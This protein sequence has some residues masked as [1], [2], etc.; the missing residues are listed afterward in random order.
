MDIDRTRRALLAA[1]VGGG[2][3]AATLSPAGDL[4]DR[5][6]AP[7]GSAWE[8]ARR[9]VPDT[10]ESPYGP[11]TVTYDDYHVPHVEADTEDAVYFAVGY[12]Q[13]ADR[14]FE[15]DLIRRRMGGTLSAAFGERTLESDRFHA[16]MDFR[17]AAEASLA[18]IEGTRAAELAAAFRDG[19][20]AYLDAGP[21]PLEFGLLGYEPREWETLDTL[22]VGQQISWGL[23]GSFDTLRQGVLREE[24][25]AGTYRELFPARLPHDSPIIREGQTGGEVHGA[26]EAGDDARVGDAAGAE[27]LDW[28]SA[29]EPPDL[30][31]SNHWVVSGEHTES[32]SPVFA[33]DPHLTLM[34]P[35]VWYE[36]HIV[37]DG[38]D[39]RGATFPGIPF[40]VTGQNDRGAWGFTNTGADV[41]DLYTYETDDAGERY[42]YDGEWRE[43]ETETRTVEV[44]GGEDREV[45]V[46]K[47]V[48]GAFLDREVNGETQHVGVAWTGMGGT[49][50]SAAIYEFSRVGSMDEFRDALRRFDVPTQNA[51]YADRDGETLYH[52]T[53]KIPIRRADGEVVRGDRVFDGSAGE[54]EWDGFEPFAVSD[55]EGDGETPAFVPFEDKPG[56]ES[57]A[58]LGT[59]N[60]RPLDDPKYPIGQEYASG[61]RGQRIYERLDEAVENGTG[62]DREWMA[63]LQNDTLDIRARELVPAILDARDRMPA[64][65]DP[66]LDALADWDYRMDRDSAAALAFRTWY[67]EFRR[68][69]WA[70]DF[71]ELGLD[72]GYWPQ[73]RVLVSLPADHDVFDGDRAAV[74]ATAMDAAVDRIE[75][76]GWETYGDYNVTAIDHQFG[77]QVSALNYDRLPTDGSAYTVFNFRKEGGAGS[78]WRMITPMGEAESR[79]VIPGGQDGSY[80]SEHYDDQLELWADGEYKPM[81]REMP[82]GDPDVTVEGGSE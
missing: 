36:Q 11:A 46:R 57:P 62:V 67:E 78:S 26:A 60:Q 1:V 45:A 31:G 74:L 3:G 43:F 48:H 64:K 71:E 66:W 44:S 61:F 82:D 53:G 10:V 7:S 37:A 47:T 23:T 9:S 58:Y 30:L 79:S 72:D 5:F 76:E 40:V 33:Y 29:F 18:A 38:V 27:L 4:L 73:E 21:L 41:V 56:V 54:V 34:V 14:L 24:L 77:G 42:R 80:F 22:L 28:L 25:D 68:A 32:G 55:W 69:T 75:D 8:S 51:M 13:A 59:A 49:R 12:A 63:S 35:P 17:G 16:K 39:V 50:E 70:D 6:A 2:V 52:T 15:M 20:N 81:R 19:V 65:A